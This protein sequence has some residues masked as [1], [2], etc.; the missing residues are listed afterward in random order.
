MNRSPS[1]KSSLAF[2]LEPLSKDKPCGEFLRYSETYDQIREAR[3][4]EDE[5][6]PQGVWKTETKKADWDQVEHLC[7]DALK[8]RTKDLQIAAW[9][10]EAYLHLEGMGGLVRGLDLILGLTHNFWDN[11]HPQIDGTNIE[12]RLIPYEWM[13]TCLSEK[14]QSVLISMPADRAH[15][16]QRLI[17]FNEA[18]RIE[19]QPK[20]SSQPELPQAPN[21]APRAP[22]KMSL[23][24]DQTPTAFYDCLSENCA[25]ALHRLTEL[26][27]ELGRH[28]AADAPTFHRLREKIE[29][30]QHF[31]HQIL[32]NRGKKEK[33]KTG[34]LGMSFPRSPKKTIENS[35]ESREQA[36]RTLEEVATYLE[37]IE[38]H[39]PTPYLIRRAISWGSMSLPQ[40]LADALANGKDISLLLDVLNVEKKSSTS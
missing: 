26:T 40:V 22:N 21:D 4:E 19:L 2:L 30:V 5:H 1:S 38:P 18:Q 11:I 39:S 37:R 14:C 6:L 31:A 8:N 15:R 16:P 32:K 35:F 20:K 13:N 10:T 25:L 36:Y 28:L 27:A 3:R 29:V 17:D 33:K 23:S 7:Q 9:L 34:L 24:I 12:L